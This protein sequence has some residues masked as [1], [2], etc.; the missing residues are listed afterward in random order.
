MTHYYQTT[1]KVKTQ[2]AAMRGTAFW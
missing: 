1:S 2:N